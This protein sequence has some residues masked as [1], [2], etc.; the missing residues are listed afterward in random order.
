MS[1]AG[2]VKPGGSRTPTESGRQDLPN[3]YDP[4]ADDAEGDQM[5]D[6]VNGYSTSKLHVSTL[7]LPHAGELAASQLELPAEEP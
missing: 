2:T 1:R 4:L 5:H 7:P 3:E 6:S